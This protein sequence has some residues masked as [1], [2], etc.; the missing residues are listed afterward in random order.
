[1]QMDF[2]FSLSLKPFTKPIMVTRL[3]SFRNQE[4]DLK[5]IKDVFYSVPNAI[6][7]RMTQLFSFLKVSL[8]QQGV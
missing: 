1:M 2:Q 4:L 8:N 5:H 3:E 6:R 7:I